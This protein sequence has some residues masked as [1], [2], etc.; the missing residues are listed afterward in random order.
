MINNGTQE[1]LLGLYDA[2]NEQSELRV[3]AFEKVQL[4]FGL[5]LQNE[6][7]IL[8]SLRVALD[9]QAVLIVSPDLPKLLQIAFLISFKQLFLRWIIHGCH[10]NRIL[11]Q[12]L[13][14]LLLLFFLFLALLGKFLLL[15]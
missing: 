13:K 6:I 1:V 15:C 7:W 12:T 8:H 9:S 11:L 3:L 5:R 2:Q 10:V 14:L 4:R